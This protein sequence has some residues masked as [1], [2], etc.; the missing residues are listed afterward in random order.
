MDVFTFCSSSSQINLQTRH[1]ADGG[2]LRISVCSAKSKYDLVVLKGRLTQCSGGNGILIRL[3][4]GFIWTKIIPRDK[5]GPRVYP[6]PPKGGREEW[7]LKTLVLK[8]DELRAK[9]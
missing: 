4:D 1:L 2:S 7:H 5:D 8:S 6:Y 3:P 9:S